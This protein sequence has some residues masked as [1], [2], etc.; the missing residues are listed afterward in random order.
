MTNVINRGEAH[1]IMRTAFGLGLGGQ[2][3][4]GRKEK[5]FLAVGRGRAWAE[6]KSRSKSLL[7]VCSYA[8]SS[9]SQVNLE[10]PSANSHPPPR[11]QLKGEC[12][13]LAIGKEIL[14]LG[15]ED[16]P[17]SQALVRSY[18]PLT[19]VTCAIFYYLVHSLEW[20]LP[21]T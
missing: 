14:Q 4:G 13:D 20:C 16:I 3:R 1:S 8:A 19:W 15:T 7:P 12:S 6:M 5:A 2:T 10:C 9:G 18:M 17:C 11:P 21:S